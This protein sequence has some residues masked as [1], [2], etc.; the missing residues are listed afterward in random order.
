[1]TG[2]VMPTIEPPPPG[3][4]PVATTSAKKIARRET[5]RLLMRRPEF[6][7]GIG[8]TLF[9][10]ICAIGGER[11]APHD[12]YAGNPLFSHS[13]PGADGWSFVL[14]TDRLGR[15]VLSRII[16]GSQDVLVAAPAAAVIGV[17]LGTLLGL[18]MGYYR[19]LVD[20]EIG[21]AHV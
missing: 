14:G 11:L 17:A 13:P 8:V 20:D 21:R 12:P 19:G 2:P 1:M 6:L 9:W 10:V 4:V 16:V 7:I 3:A 5:I 18:V 15:D